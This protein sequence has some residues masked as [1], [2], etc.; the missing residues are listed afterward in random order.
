MTALDAMHVL[1]CHVTIILCIEFRQSDSEDT[2]AVEYAALF[3][4][5]VPK[6]V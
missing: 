4:Y 5:L 6:I 3:R 2:V 1:V